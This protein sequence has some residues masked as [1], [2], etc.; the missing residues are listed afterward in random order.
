MANVTTNNIRSVVT[1]TAQG[2][3]GD[4]GD[5]GAFSPNE[6][7]TINFSGSKFSGS[8]LISMTITGSI[9]PEGNGNW[10]LLV[11]ELVE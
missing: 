2:P 11:E 8:M 3:K 1:V 6:N 9:I 10:D 5:K 7:Q 4:K